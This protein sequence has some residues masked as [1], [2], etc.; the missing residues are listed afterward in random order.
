MS[1]ETEQKLT[2]KEAICSLVE[3]LERIRKN[4]NSENEIAIY[5]GY[6]PQNIFFYI[7]SGHDSWETKEPFFEN[8]EQIR[9]SDFS[10][11]EISEYFKSKIKTP[12]QMLREEIAAE[13]N[14][15]ATIINENKS[16]IEGLKSELARLE[17]KERK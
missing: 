9:A 14:K 8:V 1:K 2:I 15:L 12:E 7:A 13:E 17:E 4:I 16:K 5:L 3:S 11:N 10:E 6:E